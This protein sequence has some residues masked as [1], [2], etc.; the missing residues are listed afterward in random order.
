LLAEVAGN[1]QTRWDAHLQEVKSFHAT[2]QNYFVALAQ[3]GSR[4]GLADMALW[5]RWP[6][7]ARAAIDEQ[8]SARVWP[9]LVWVT[10]CAFALVLW[11]QR[12]LARVA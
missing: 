8:S 11:S 9:T 6:H 7:A 12:S 4:V 1:G 10:V 3:S 2:W 5:P